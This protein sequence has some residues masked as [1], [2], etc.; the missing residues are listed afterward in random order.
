[1]ADVRGGRAEDSEYPGPAR[2]L[3]DVWIAVRGSLREILEGTSLDDLVRG[4]MPKAI[5]RQTEDPAAWTSIGRIR[6]AARSR[7]PRPVRKHIPKPGTRQP[8]PAPLSEPSP[9]KP[10]PT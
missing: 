10:S 3:Q 9:G 7:L 5:R 2:R 1:M 8:P 4:K 6:G